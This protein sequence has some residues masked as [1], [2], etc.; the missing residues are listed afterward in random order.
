VSDMTDQGSLRRYRLSRRRLIGGGATLGLGA[1]SMALIGCGSTPAPTPAAAPKQAAPAVLTPAPAAKAKPGGELRIAVDADPVSYDPHIEASYRTQWAVGGAYNRVLGLTTD[2]K[3]TPELAASWETP[4]PTT[5]VLK[6]Q[7]GVKFH[8]VAP[9]NG[10]ALTAEDIVWSIQRITTNKPEFQRRYM[11]D[12]IDKITAT[13]ANT[14]NIKLKQAFSPLFGYLANPFTVVAPKEGLNDKGDLRTGAIGTGPFVFKS[15]QKGVSYKW[16]KNPAYWEKEMPYLDSYTLNVVPDASTR[17]SSLRAKQLDFEVVTPDQASTLKGDNAFVL[18]S[19]AQGNNFTIRYNTT[20]PPFND[21]RV[22]KAFDL[23]ID[24]KQI[25]ALVFGGSA[26]A[27]GPI[28]PGLT[29][30]SMSQEDL[31]KAPGY[32][33][34]KAADIAEAKKLLEAA[35][36]ANAE[37]EYVYYTPAVVHEQVAQTAQQQ[38]EKAGLKVKLNKMQYAAWIPFTL[39]K[40]FAMTGTSSG[41]RDN[42]D[43]YL[44]ALFHSTSSRNDTGYNNPEI[45]KLL[46]L[47]RAQLKEEERKATVMELQKRLMAELPNSWITGD[48]LTEARHAYVKGYVPT[49]THNRPRQLVRAWMDK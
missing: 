24:R 17:L 44:Y 40:K 28:N 31:L 48:T 4:D 43:E 13:D 34:D 7:Q 8:N 18:D 22:R 25:A 39:E 9:V 41:F 1:V 45:D 10:R 49:Y 3:I 36:L 46:E 23:I 12:A 37:F 14:V 15:G 42:P 35:G 6:V 30:W 27:S 19:V 32:R 16:E 5:V 2:L 26:L 47:Q 33:A 20:R 38:L 11:F 29:A 21:V